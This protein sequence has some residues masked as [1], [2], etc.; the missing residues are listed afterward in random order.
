MDAVF[1]KLKSLHA[2]RN[3]QA[4]E[5][6]KKTKDFVFGWNVEREYMQ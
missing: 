6:K 1:E 3:S 5:E 2:K 4:N